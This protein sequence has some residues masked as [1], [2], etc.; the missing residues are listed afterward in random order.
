MPNLP[1]PALAYRCAPL[2]CM[3]E[4]SAYLSWYEISSKTVLLQGVT[5]EHFFLQTQKYNLL[6]AYFEWEY[7]TFLFWKTQLIHTSHCYIVP[8]YISRKVACICGNEM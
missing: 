2:P 3:S 4:D 5:T 7:Y 1:E 8:I 6:P